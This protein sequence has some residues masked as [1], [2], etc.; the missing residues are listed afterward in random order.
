MLSIFINSIVNEF[1]NLLFLY[2]GL[3]F[4]ILAIIFYLK[5]NSGYQ[6]YMKLGYR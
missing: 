3:R 1:F 6:I 2:V 4:S 5:E